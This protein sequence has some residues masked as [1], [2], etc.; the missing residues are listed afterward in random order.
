MIVKVFPE[1]EETVTSEPS[2]PDSVGVICNFWF[3]VYLA[4]SGTV[5]VVAD[6]KIVVYKFSVLNLSL[7]YNWIFPV[8][9]IPFF[10]APNYKFISLDK[11]V[12]SPNNWI[13]IMVGK[14]TSADP[15]FS[16]PYFT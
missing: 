11:L 6:F 9:T 1:I 2:N 7:P 16:S 14:G 8:F 10:T 13:I 4:P 3:D 5:I 12:E 15:A